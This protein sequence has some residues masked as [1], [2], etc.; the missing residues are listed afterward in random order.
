[1]DY[2]EIIKEKLAEMKRD[3][4]T[5]EEIAKET[6]ITQSHISKLMSAKCSIEKI[7][8]IRLESFFKL[9]PNARIVFDDRRTIGDVTNNSGQVVNGDVTAPLPPPPSARAA[10]DAVIARIMA[11]DDLDAETKV[12]LYTLLQRKP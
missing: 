6:G 4:K 8:R 10:E 12:K 11:S 3:G 2:A 9:F 1:M 7:K 5:Q